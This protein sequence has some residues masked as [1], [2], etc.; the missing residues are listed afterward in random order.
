[1]LEPVREKQS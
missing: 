1:M